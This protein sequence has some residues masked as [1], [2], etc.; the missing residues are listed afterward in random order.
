[1][2]Q[3]LA[4][5]RKGKFDIF[6]ISQVTLTVLYIGIVTFIKDHFSFEFVAAKD[7]DVVALV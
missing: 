3:G 1:M 2:R 5:R 7:A 4:G 6:W